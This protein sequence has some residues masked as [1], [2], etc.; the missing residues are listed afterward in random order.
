MTTTLTY[1][2]FDG[3]RGL[4]ARLALSAAGV[5][6]VDNRIKREQWMAL[7]PATSFGG[8]PRLEMDGRSLFQSTAILCYLGRAH[9]LHP[10]DPWVAAEHEAIM[11]SVTDLRYKVPGGKHLSADEKK[12]AREAFAQGWLTRWATSV[13][14]RVVGPFI[15]GDTLHVADLK[16]YV[17]LRSWTAGVYDH[18][19]ASAL[20]AWPKLVALRDAVESHPAVLGYFAGRSA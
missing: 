11:Q 18:I 2:D 19:P 17:I 7:K 1:F 12:A 20:D 8:L 6:F 4:E 10:A 15:E 3:S 16:V 9:G 5:D 14:E 13:S